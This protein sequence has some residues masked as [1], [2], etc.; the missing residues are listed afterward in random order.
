FI[1]DAVGI[2]TRA[3]LNLDNVMWEVDYPHSDSTWPLSPEVAMKYLGDLPDDEVNRI[4]HLNAMRHFQ[5]DP[6]ARIP[7]EEATVGAL[8]KRAEGWDISPK[9]A[10]E[11][12]AS[13][14]SGD[15]KSLVNVSGAPKQ[16]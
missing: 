3:H 16:G 9:P 4:T 5:Y 2:E 7:K 10:A 14:T 13:R 1:D 11:Q 8:R 15:W 6:F 12:R